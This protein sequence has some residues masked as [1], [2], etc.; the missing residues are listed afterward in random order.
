MCSGPRRNGME[1]CSEVKQSLQE[2]RQL[3]QAA[4][5]LTSTHLQSLVGLSPSAWHQPNANYIHV[6][7]ILH[8]Q[9]KHGEDAQ[10]L[11]SCPNSGTPSW[12]HV[13]LVRMWVQA[14]GPHLEKGKLHEWGSSAAG[15][16]HT[17]L[18]FPPLYLSGCLNP[19]NKNN[20]K[21]K[22][23]TIH[24]WITAKVKEL[25]YRLWKLRYILLCWHTR[26]SKLIS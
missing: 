15:V 24:T 20:T 25:F 26:N 23:I 6:S 12:M 8:F 9:Y 14:S 22:K 5:Y 3:Q 19:I 10:S 17:L 13:T 16:S 4:P 11:C 1:W 2:K 21:K 7:T 18:L